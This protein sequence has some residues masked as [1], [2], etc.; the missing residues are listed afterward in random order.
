MRL[1][2]ANVIFVTNARLCCRDT[3]P[4]SPKKVQI[5]VPWR[6]GNQCNKKTW[7]GNI[8]HIIVYPRKMNKI[9]NF[10]DSRNILTTSQLF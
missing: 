8:I 4:W 5:V 1:V 10:I 6:C 9:N 2:Q 7:V 3:E